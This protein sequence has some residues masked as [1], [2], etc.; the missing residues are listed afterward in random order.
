ML[1]WLTVAEPGSVLYSSR[2]AFHLRSQLEKLRNKIMQAVFSVS[3]T[4][5]L[6]TELSDTYILESLQVRRVKLSTL[7]TTRG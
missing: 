6:S 4:K 2:G 1:S 5:N 3:G 7:P